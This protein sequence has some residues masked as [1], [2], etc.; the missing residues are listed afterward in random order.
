MRQFE[1]ARFYFDQD[2]YEKSV[3]HYAKGI[4]AV[5]KLGIAQS[6]PIGFADA[7]E[8]YSVALTQA[9]RATDAATTKQ[10]ASQ[11]REQNPG[12]KA[13]SIPTRYKCD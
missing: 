13:R 2:Q 4:P 10:K 6:D 7:L 3:T 1:L 12:A 11:L 8:E 5:E 9:G